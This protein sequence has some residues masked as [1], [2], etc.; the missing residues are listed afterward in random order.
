MPAEL[1]MRDKSDSDFMWHF[2]FFEKKTLVLIYSL[3]VAG[4]NPDVTAS[5]LF[6]ERMNGHYNTSIGNWSHFL[7]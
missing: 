4:K 2:C 5:R 3:F 1:D 7:Q 6:P